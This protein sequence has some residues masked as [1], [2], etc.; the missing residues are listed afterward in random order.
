MR[1]WLVALIVTCVLS[2][3]LLAAPAAALT[4]SITTVTDNATGL[5]TGGT[6]VFTATVAGNPV[7]VIP[8]GTLTWTVTDP[9]GHAVTCP[10]S[11]T[12]D[13]TGKG[14][15]TIADALAGTYSATANYGG[16]T[17]YSPSM[18]LDTTA[19]VKTMPTP[20]TI[21]DLPPSGGIIPLGGGGG[22]TAMV[23]PTGVGY[24]T[25]SVTS[26]STTV[27]TATSLTVAYVAAGTCSLTAHLA[28]GRPTPRPTAPPRPSA[29][30][31]RRPRRPSPTC[32]R[33]APTAAASPP[34]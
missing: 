24:G 33:A 26:N 17:N 11:T 7:G 1:N 21:T 4:P 25:P 22:F 32:R 15:C 14:T 8:T 13:A 6:L 31:P 34:W 30:M 10:D 20:P 18:G 3:S 5:V 23:S 27:C 9:L 28:A 12:L 16:D 19:I 2:L 29:S